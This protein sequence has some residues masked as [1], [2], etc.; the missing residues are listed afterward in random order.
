MGKTFRSAVSTIVT[1]HSLLTTWVLWYHLLHP[2]P[3]PLFQRSL[4]AP[5]TRTTPSYMAW[6][7]PL[8]GLAA[9]CGIWTLPLR[10]RSPIAG[11]FLVAL[12]FFSSAYVLVWVIDISVTIARERERNTYDLLCLFPSGALGANWA[13]CAASL[14][15]N[16]ALGWIDLLRK[17]I[18]GILLLI[19]LLILIATALRQSAPQPYQQFWRLFLDIIV[20][21]VVS[22][23]DHV[24]AVVLGS[25]V[26][27]LVPVYRRTLVSAFVWAVMVFLALQAATFMLTVFAAAVILPG[28]P[29]DLSPL[30]VS[31]LVGYL[32]REGFIV[33]LWRALAYQLNA[34]P[35]VFSLLS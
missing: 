27:M 15:R 7:V 12:F 17:L 25:L 5:L 16:N 3:H 20:L 21:S 34:H 35:A 31:L 33:S 24:Q 4:R 22:Y 2:A 29:L 10:W 13:I 28:L 19:F 11:L 26:G 8:S 6:I 18:A 30:L 1:R 32:A 23:V 9:C 14:H